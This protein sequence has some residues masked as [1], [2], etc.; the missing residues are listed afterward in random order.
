MFEITITQYDGKWGGY[1]QISFADA[2]N[3]FEWFMHQDDDL[4]LFSAN[5]TKSTIKAHS[6]KTFEIERV[7]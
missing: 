3:F 1:T 4:T 6:I 5:G 7:G 2:C